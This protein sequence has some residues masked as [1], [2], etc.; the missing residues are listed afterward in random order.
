[1]DYY[2]L[3]VGLLFILAVADLVV[4]V[5]NDAVNFLNSS[6]GIGPAFII[7]SMKSVRSKLFPKRAFSAAKSAVNCAP[8][9]K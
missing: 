9:K 8:P 4:G 2:L 3:V 5:S 7:V 1:M 6:I